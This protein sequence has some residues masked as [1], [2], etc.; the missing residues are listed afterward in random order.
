MNASAFITMN[1]EQITMNYEI[2]NEPKTNPN[3]ANL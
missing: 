1:Y 3:K 2:K